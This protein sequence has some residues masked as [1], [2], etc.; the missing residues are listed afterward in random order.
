[1]NS[2]GIAYFYIV[3]YDTMDINT[4]NNLFSPLHE[5]KDALHKFDFSSSDKK[6]R[7]IQDTQHGHQ[8]LSSSHPMTQHIYRWQCEGGQQNYVQVRDLIIKVG[9]HSNHILLPLTRVIKLL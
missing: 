7:S 5:S 2:T 9:Q 8:D 1:M 3:S 6:N 4:E